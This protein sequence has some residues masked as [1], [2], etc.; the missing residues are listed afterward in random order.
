MAES[1]FIESIISAEIM[2]E[3]NSIIEEREIDD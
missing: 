1:T 2:D 3:R